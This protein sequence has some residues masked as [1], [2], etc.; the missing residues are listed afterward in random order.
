MGY[1]LECMQIE[2]MHP[3]GQANVRVPLGNVPGTVGQDQGAIA[4]F[5]EKK[6]EGLLQIC[7]KTPDIANAIAMVTSAGVKMID[8]TGRA[9]GRGG[10]IAFMDRRD[11]HG[12]LLHF[13]ERTPM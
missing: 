12:V 9:G 7:F 5:L 4:R 3:L 10:L 6:G 2:I 13:A 1:V 8:P 11:T